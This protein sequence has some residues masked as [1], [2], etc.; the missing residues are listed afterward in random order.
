MGMI[1]SALPIAAEVALGYVSESYPSLAGEATTAVIV[2]R[3]VI[4]C[5]M[6]FAIG[7]WIESSGLRDTFVAVGLLAFVVVSGILLL[8]WGKR[9]RGLGAKRYHAIVA[10]KG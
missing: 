7:P 6:T 5:A 2:I 9:W 1:G 8:L 10:M 3:N 4:G